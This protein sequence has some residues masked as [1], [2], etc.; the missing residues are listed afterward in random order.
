MTLTGCR[1]VHAVKGPSH[2]PVPAPLRKQLE[3]RQ[4][5]EAGNNSHYCLQ[6]ETVLASANQ[7]INANGLLKPAR[8]QRPIA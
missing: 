2:G 8:Q 6:S 4:H 7:Q 1:P 5:R 3:M